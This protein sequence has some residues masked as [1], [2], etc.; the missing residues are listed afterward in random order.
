MLSA[1]RPLGGVWPGLHSP[2]GQT[3]DGPAAQVLHS[4]GVHGGLPGGV[5]GSPEEKTPWD[6]VEIFTDV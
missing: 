6:A 5:G 3:P 1:S 4:F 2:T